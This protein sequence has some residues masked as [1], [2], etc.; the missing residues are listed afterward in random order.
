[1]TSSSRWFVGGSVPIES[2]QSGA[3]G[4][5]P[6]DGGPLIA[7]VRWSLARPYAEALAIAEAIVAAHNAAIPSETP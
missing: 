4:I 1:M 5:H 3:I 7:S 6:V 2:D